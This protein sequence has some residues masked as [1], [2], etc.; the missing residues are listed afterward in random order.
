MD[1]F[2]TNFGKMFKRKIEECFICYAPNS[3]DR[4]LDLEIPSALSAASSTSS[5]L[6]LL[7]GFACSW[8]TS[9]S[10]QVGQITI[11]FTQSMHGLDIH[12]GHINFTGTY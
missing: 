2:H 10:S 9:Q 5:N 1:A 4:E 3:M 6:I 7:C 8:A 12:F 11:N